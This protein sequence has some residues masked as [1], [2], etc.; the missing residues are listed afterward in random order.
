[1][2]PTTILKINSRKEQAI[3]ELIKEI[4]VEYGAS[5]FKFT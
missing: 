5:A 3:S 1:M 2:K 4:Y